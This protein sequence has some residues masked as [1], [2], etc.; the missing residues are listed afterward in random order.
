MLKLIIE[1]QKS[2]L[3]FLELHFLHIDFFSSKQ[4]ICFITLHLLQTLFVKSISISMGLGLEIELEIE[5]KLELELR[6]GLE[7]EL[8]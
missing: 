5:L 8:G 1:G 4:V 3:I 6:L 2:H 7:L